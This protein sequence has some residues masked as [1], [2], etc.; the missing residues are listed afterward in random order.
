V[1]GVLWHGGLRKDNQEVAVITGFYRSP[2]IAG[3][4]IIDAGIEHSMENSFSLRFCD[5]AATRSA[6]EL[7]GTVAQHGDLE[8]RASE[9]SLG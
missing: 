7:H 1:R 2:G 6:T 4:D 8:A 3:I 5:V 9:F